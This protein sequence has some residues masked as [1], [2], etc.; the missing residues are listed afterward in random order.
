MQIKEKEATP[1]LLLLLLTSIYFQEKEVLIPNHYID[2]ID[3][4]KIPL[5]EGAKLALINKVKSSINDSNKSSIINSL[6]IKVNN[7]DKY[8]LNAL[9]DPQTAGGFLFLLKPSEKRVIEELRQK[10]IKCT[11]IGNTQ[12]KN[13]KIN[14]L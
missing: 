4:N 11:L 9:F 5:Y 10:G 12:T 8:L 6:N 1:L 7:N 3:H 13:M 2:I 14:I